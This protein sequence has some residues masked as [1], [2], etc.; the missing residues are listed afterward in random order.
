VK[1]SWADVISKF[2]S[3]FISKS[4]APATSKAAQENKGLESKKKEALTKSFEHLGATK[5][6]LALV[7]L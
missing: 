7:K 2:I 1:R 3:K 6:K 5:L 4:A